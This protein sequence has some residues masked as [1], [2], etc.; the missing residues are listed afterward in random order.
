[1]VDTLSPTESGR[2]KNMRTNKGL[3]GRE[4]YD[5]KD[6][7][8]GLTQEELVLIIRT[9]EWARKMMGK[10][11]AAAARAEERLKKDTIHIAVA[12]DLI[13]NTVEANNDAYDELSRVTVVEGDG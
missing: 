11:R 10:Y 6:R 3:T 4:I 7:G 8:E 2:R 9:H 1:M 5:L 13:S 12:A